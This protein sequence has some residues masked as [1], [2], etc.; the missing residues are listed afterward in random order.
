ML[1]KWTTLGY[2]R[3][4]CAMI[5]KCSNVRLQDPKYCFILAYRRPTAL[6]VACFCYA[7]VCSNC[8]FWLH[9]RYGI[10]QILHS[11]T[12]QTYTSFPDSNTRCFS[13][14]QIFH[15]TWKFFLG[16]KAPPKPDWIFLKLVT[17]PLKLIIRRKYSKSTVKEEKCTT[18]IGKNERTMAS[19]DS[20]FITGKILFWGQRGLDCT[21]PSCKGKA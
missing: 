13:Y 15:Q 9:V 8:E 20:C 3:P 17:K 21:E 5:T 4:L 19:I 16:H 10:I 11:K 1:W 7:S 18:S 14:A 6:C 12:W 2:N